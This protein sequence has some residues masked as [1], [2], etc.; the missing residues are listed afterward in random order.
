[1]KS[2]NFQIIWPILT[3][4][5]VYVYIAF[6]NLPIIF[7][8]R[9]RYNQAPKICLF[10]LIVQYVLIS[11]SL[12][13]LFISPHH[14]SLSTGV[15]K[16]TKKLRDPYTIDNNELLDFLSRVP[17]DVQ[18]VG[19]LSIFISVSSF[20]SFFTTHLSVPD[21]GNAPFIISSISTS[22]SFL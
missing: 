22:V 8:F 2:H 18:V 5:L 20:I 7:E 4:L 10:W 19:E 16:F 12:L 21:T 6:L 17:S 11:T 14:L 9:G 3:K 13:H 15:N 1:M